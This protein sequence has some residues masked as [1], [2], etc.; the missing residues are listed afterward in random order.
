MMKKPA[1]K[2]IAALATIAIGLLTPVFTQSAYFLT[3]MSSAMICA[4]IVIGL[5]FVTGL[6]GQMNLGTAGI[7]ALGAY[8]SAV[9]T[10]QLNVPPLLTIPASLVVGGLLGVLLGY[11]SMR[12]Q[13][14]YLAITTI[15]FTEVV[16]ILIN[17]A[18]ITGGANGLMNIPP[19]ELFGYELTSAN[20]IYY[21]N[22]VMLVI[23]AFIAFRI[24]NS[25]WGRIFKALRD[26]PDAVGAAGV[27]I[28]NI[29]ILSF[30]LAM[31]LGALGGSLYTFQTRF[32]SPAQYTQAYS[33]NFVLMMILG[34]S[35]SVI[36]SIVGAFVVTALPEGLR[37]LNDYYWLITSVVTL[38]FIIFLPNGLISIFNRSDKNRKPSPVSRWI[39]RVK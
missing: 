38:L 4:V 37:F 16:R 12:V 17:N 3:I 39:R 23:V 32:I 6:T 27:N 33:T 9:L 1:F 15:G 24:V 25:K 20:A 18:K 22:F 34:G 31:M 30:V 29:K 13:G 28:T 21:F 8:T 11:P 7:V 14:V 10:M 2:T 26:E 5:N 35:G 19:M 36:G